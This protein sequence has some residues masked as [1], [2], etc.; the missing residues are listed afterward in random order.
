MPP[1][2]VLII[3]DSAVVRAA[4]DDIF[5]EAKGIE[6]IGKASN[7]YH[8]AELIKQQVPDVIT[9]DLEMPRMDGLTFLKKLM[10]QHPLPVVVCSSL[11]QEGADAAMNALELGAVDIVAKPKL[12]T[13]DF[14]FESKER[15]CDVVRAAAKANVSRRSRSPSKKRSINDFI[16]AEKSHA[17]R[18]TTDKII[19]IGASTGGTEALLSFLQQMPEDCPGILIV[20]H[21]PAHFTAPFAK[22]L[23]QVCRINVEEASDGQSLLQGQALI[24]PGGKHMALKRSGARY[25][26]SIKEGPL[27]NRH[28]PS[29]DVLFRSTA[30]HAGSNAVGVIMTGMGDDGAQGCLDMKEAGATLFAQDEQTSVV[31]GMP[32]AAIAKGGI[33]KVLPLN[34]LPSAALARTNRLLQKQAK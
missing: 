23:N 16:P 2:K 20:Q 29:V 26:V 12:G 19:V 32:K 6:V 7:P 31:F 5:T 21:M 11:A 3:D 28:R 10:S 8:A 22:R 27:V 1:T 25:R 15:L 17:L 4:L 9:L 30:Y 18:E 24:A 33:H 13:H 34:D 14:L